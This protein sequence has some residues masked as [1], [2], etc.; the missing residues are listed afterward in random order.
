MVTAATAASLCADPTWLAF[1]IRLTMGSRICPLGLAELLDDG[2]R[3]ARGA[4][5]DVVSF[6]DGGTAFAGGDVH[7]LEDGV[8][9]FADV[10][11]RRFKSYCAQTFDSKRHH[12]NA[13]GN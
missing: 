12:L 9:T 1:W 13:G 3:L 6:L 7:L 4:S 11:G 5:H 2:G 8:L 10:F